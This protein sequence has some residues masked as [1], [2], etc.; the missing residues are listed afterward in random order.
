MKSRN[1]FGILPFLNLLVPVPGHRDAG[2]EPALPTDGGPHPILHPVL[3][4]EML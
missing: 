1:T 2:T 4:S 3:G